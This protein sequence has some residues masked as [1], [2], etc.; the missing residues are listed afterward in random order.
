MVFPSVEFLF[1]FFPVFLLFYT[2]VPYKNLSILVFSLIF[3]AWG[4]GVYILLLLGTIVINFIAA[5]QLSKVTVEGAKI[6]LSIGVFLDLAILFYYK[7]FGFIV[8]SVLKLP[9]PE[10]GFPLLPLGISFFIFQSISYLVDVYRKDAPPAD[11]L[12][13]VALYISMFPQLIAGPI[14]RYSF[15]AEAIKTRTVELEQFRDGTFLFVGGMCSKVL[16]ANNAAEISDV[17]FSLPLEQISSLTA[18]IG[19]IAYAIQIFFDFAGYST[20]AIG[21]GLVMGFRFPLNFNYPYVA[22]SITNF[23]RRWHMSLSSWFRDYL[24]IPLGGNQK[25]S[26]RTYVNL[27]LVFFLCGLWHGA[28]WNFVIWGMF[29]GFLLVIERLGL[30]GILDGGPRFLA[31]IY[32]LLMVLIGWILFR[33]ESMDQAIV[34]IRSLFII[35]DAEIPSELIRILNYENLLF[36]LMGIIL[37]MPVVP[38]FLKVLNIFPSMDVHE[39]YSTMQNTMVVTLSL[40]GMAI[41]SIYVIS[42]TYN[43]FIYFRF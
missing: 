41:C 11:S 15:V 13:D 2:V 28:A 42:G 43:P 38:R 18:W 30:K 6:I 17:A 26:V 29:H 20:M 10:D 39:K 36:I 22:C 34:F 7:Y 40:A 4:E 12:F 35:R 21:I 24:Y 19:S 3:Y 31:H 5:K 14:V 9:I 27:F 8:G 25:G 16:I 33:A 37:S 1:F 23:W 32:T